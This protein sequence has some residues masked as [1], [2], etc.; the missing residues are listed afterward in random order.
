MQLAGTRICVG[1]VGTSK[2]GRTRFDLCEDE[3]VVRQQ[4]VTRAATKL[5][6]TLAASDV[7]RVRL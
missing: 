4:F 5:E 7:G 1:I 6:V 2:F 3:T